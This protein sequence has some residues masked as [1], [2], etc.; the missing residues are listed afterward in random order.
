MFEM[1]IQRT[2]RAIWRAERRNTENEPPDA[3][4]EPFGELNPEI[5]KM[6]SRGRQREKEGDRGRHR[7]TVG[8]IGGQ[9]ETDGD[10]ATQR[11]T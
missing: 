8:D 6:S 3:S 7:E 1:S 5:A 2:L 11:E 4:W 10:R 9:R